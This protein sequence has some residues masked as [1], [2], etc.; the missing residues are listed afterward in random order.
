MSTFNEILKKDNP[1]RKSY[2]F[3]E[4]MKFNPYHD[5]LGRF[6]SASGAASF[7][8]APG[9]S[10]AHDNAI[11]AEKQEA[12]RR[13]KR[14]YGS[15]PLG[16]AIEEISSGTD[17]SL[18]KYIDKDGKLTPEREALHKKIIDDYLYGKTGVE[19]QAEMRMYGGGPASGKSSLDKVGNQFDKKHHLKIDPDDIKEKLPGYKEMTEKTT[20]AAGYYHEESSALAKRISEVCFS[21]NINVTYDGTGDGSV[22]SVMK[23]I[24]GARARGYKVTAAYATVDTDEALRRNQARYEHMKAEGKPARLPNEQLVSETHAKVTKISLACAD[25]F[26]SIELYDNNGPRG[27][28]AVLI[29]TGGNG[30]GLTAVSGK[31]AEFAK[32]V[33]KGNNLLEK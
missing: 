2:T 32:F 15:T 17:N 24:N 3:A 25:K 22:N 29:A 26:D 9:K 8:Y 21:E 19:G 23:K 14:N 13:A 28:M 4:I 7:T 31:E 1:L 33:S 6:A 16:D 12:E 27:S 30:K 10:K 5:R 18:S 11:A 20:E